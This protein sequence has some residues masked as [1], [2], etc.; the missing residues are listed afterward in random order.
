MSFM[1]FMR[2]V[3]NWANQNHFPKR[4]I[5]NMEE[6]I[7]YI[8]WDVPIIIKDNNMVEQGSSIIPSRSKKKQMD[9]SQKKKCSKINQSYK[10]IAMEMKLDRKR[11]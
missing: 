9:S 7:F 11:Y 1:V 2:K 4:C 3:I 8:N 10:L 6:K 5:K